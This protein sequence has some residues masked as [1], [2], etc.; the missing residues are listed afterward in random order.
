MTT[1]N[2]LANGQKEL[3][4][5]KKNINSMAYKT[6][7]DCGS[8]I[9]EYGCISCNEEDY[10]SMQGI[11]DEP[12][13]NEPY[14]YKSSPPIIGSAFLKREPNGDHKTPDLKF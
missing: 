2:A 7:P 14:K 4:K 10:I 5:N 8:R 1:S 3:V 12:E 11:H 6:C 9:F 13:E